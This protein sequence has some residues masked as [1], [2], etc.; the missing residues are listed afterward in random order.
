MFDI[1]GVTKLNLWEKDWIRSEKYFINWD[2]ENISLKKSNS[3]ITFNVIL[4]T[5]YNNYEVVLWIDK[6][7]KELFWACNCDSFRKNRGCKHIWALARQIDNNYIINDDLSI[8]PKIE[9]DSKSKELSILN[10]IWKLDNDE[11][12]YDDDENLYKLKLDFTKEK[13]D[14]TIC[15]YKCVILKNWKL[16]SGKKIFSKDTDSLPNNLKKLKLFIEPKNPHNYRSNEIDNMTFLDTP[17]IFI[18]LIKQFNPIF[19]IDNNEIF[20]EKEVLNLKVKT[21]KNNNWF[22]D[23][24]LVVS[25]KTIEY[26]IKDIKFIWNDYSSLFVILDKDKHLFLWK[27]DLPNIFI[28]SIRDKILSLKNEDFE[29]F[30]KWPYFEKLLE[31]TVSIDE[32]WVKY[33]VWEPKNKFL[34]EI[35]N[36]FEKVVLEHLFSYWEKNI[37]ANDKTKNL[38]I[39]NWNVIKRNFE[40]ESKLKKD[41]NN[42]MSFFDDKEEENSTYTKYV[43]SSI[44]DFFDEIE[45][46]IN[47]W[48]DIEYKQQ[49]KKITNK[50]LW[51]NINISSWQDWFDANV[52]I[53]LWDN[54][55]EEASDVILALKQWKDRI[56]LK[57]GMTILLKDKLK[58]SLKEFEELWIN[59][60]NIW[61]TVKIS[62]FNIWLLKDKKNNSDFIDYSLDK[63]VLKLK[64]SLTNFKWVT[65]VKISKN[66][67][68]NL[69][70]YQIKWYQW[71]NFL[72][73]YNFSWILADDMWLWKTLQT[74]AIIQNEY[75]KKTLK[76]P[77][78][79]VC[80]TSLVLNWADEAKK[81]TPKL[82]VDYIKNW[83]LWFDDISKDTQLIIVSYWMM[84]NLV[85]DEKNDKKFYYLVLDEAQNIKNPVAIRTKSICKIKA[86]YRL[87]LSWTPI[88]NN[89][90]ELWS[91]FNFLMPNFLWNLSHFK[92]KYITEEW[93]MK[94]LSSKIKPFILRRTKEEVLKDLPPK[95]E[96]VIKLEMWEKQKAF[97]DKLKTT[98]RLQINKELEEKWLNK[99][100]FQVLDSLLKLRQACLM[101]ELVNM[102]WNNLKESIKI[103]YIEENIEDMIWKWHNLLIFSQFTGFLKYI[104]IVLDKKD[105]LYN[106]LDWQTKK[107]D[108]KKLVDSFNS[109][110]VNVFIISLKAWW[111]WLNLTSADYVIHLDPWWNPAVESQATDRAHRMWQ[112]K[113][114]F[115]QKL[116]VSWSIE[117][118][119]LS[120]QEKKKK[121]IDDIFS[122][123]F[124]SNLTESDIKYIFE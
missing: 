21:N 66:V 96:E 2:V 36:D 82:K 70:D 99:A 9:K 65:N 18:N 16:S 20:F 119:I 17:E 89:L 64:K 13:W 55:I 69:R 42:I 10:K 108:R 43:D 53:K 68:A 8:I 34:L 31:N 73:E 51:A 78:L 61:D 1:L 26:K 90:M 27:T 25:W 112:E 109:W 5:V 117:E 110:N 103:K 74:L 80:P 22:Y 81:F 111:T 11:K 102:A 40:Q 48:I 86:K 35:S 121:L 116:I 24:Y 83:K 87:A 7:D 15:L 56:T 91:I 6:T 41:L 46:L 71:L 67:E 76:T 32:M 79:I 39:D 23:M 98:F 93:N 44:D 52:E 58:D 63:E 33:S 84:A 62:K 72:S 14:I 88:E 57:N 37:I 101:P 59:E 94:L 3:R 113:T 118:K 114:V 75:D 54:V 122:G 77:S 105:I 92:H 12:S 115:V 4:E 45:V 30:K 47:K 123:N 106:Y 120:L 100:R 85:D 38:L 95:V 49:V 50:E 28:N 107:E 104:K 124:S 60:K 29:E 97:Y 19:D